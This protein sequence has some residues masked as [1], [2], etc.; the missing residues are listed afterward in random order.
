MESFKGLGPICLAALVLTACGQS[1]NQDQAARTAD[2]AQSGASET[3]FQMQPGRYHATV[4]TEALEIPG[5]PAAMADQVK[6][7]MGPAAGEDG[8][9]TP[10]RAARGI[11]VVKEQMARG[12]CRFDRFVARDGKVDAA[13]TCQTGE[14]MAM[15]ATSGGTYSPTG[16]TVRVDGTLSG[17]GGKTMHVVQVVKTARIGDCT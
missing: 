6:S 14:G 12:Q 1:G 2:K 9:I 16:L 8:C 7:M 3:P 13:F 4:T 11:D 15:Q 17:P 10:V 5:M